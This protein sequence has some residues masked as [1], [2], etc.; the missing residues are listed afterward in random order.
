MEM[1]VITGHVDRSLRRG[2]RS[3]FAEAKTI[4]CVSCL[5]E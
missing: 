3:T 5:L 2:F 1:M 4:E